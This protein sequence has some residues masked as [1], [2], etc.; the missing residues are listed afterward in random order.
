MYWIAPEQLDVELHLGHFALEHIGVA[1]GHGRIKQLTQFVIDD[2]RGFARFTEC[3]SGCLLD[4]DIATSTSGSDSTQWRCPF[5]DLITQEAFTWRLRSE[6]V[7]AKAF[8]FIAANRLEFVKVSDRHKGARLVLSC[9]GADMSRRRISR[10][11][12]WPT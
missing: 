10:C 7:Q 3:E 6:S 12:V 11:L 1:A 9:D 2:E 4:C 8:G 5:A